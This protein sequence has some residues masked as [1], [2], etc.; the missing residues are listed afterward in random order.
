MNAL[1]SRYKAL[2]PL[3][4]F[5]LRYF[6]WIFLLFALFYFKQFSPFII[7]N[8][9]HTELSIVL[10]GVWINIF[11]I[12]ITM[13]GES[14]IFRHGMVLKI[15]DECNGLAP[16]LFYLS[17]LLAYPA[18]TKD[19]LIWVVAGYL[20]LMSANAIRIDWILYHV[21]DHP[22]DFWFAH[23]VVGRYTVALIPLILFY[24]FTDRYTYVKEQMS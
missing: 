18:R 11:D 15:L 7:L 1:V 23:E 12:P 21:I 4:G 19:K 10:T 24:F 6:V 9:L 13:S 2:H 5:V 17:A 20:L 14:L 3:W 22:E 8:T 16:F